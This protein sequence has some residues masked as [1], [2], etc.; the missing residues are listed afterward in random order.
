[1][2]N[3]HL[4]NCLDIY[5]F[6]Y[7]MDSCNISKDGSNLPDNIAVISI[8]D[9][10]NSKYKPYHYFTGSTTRIL[11]IDFDDIDPND[12][13]YEY[14]YKTADNG[15]VIYNNYIL[16]HISDSQSKEIVDFILNNKGKNFWIHCYAGISRSKA[17][18][19]FIADNIDGYSLSDCPQWL[20]YNTPNIYV[21]NKLTEEYKKII[22]C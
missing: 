2:E 4:L 22:D 8:C 20:N 7:I 15:Y 18:V 17:I 21:L 10:N 5:T 13:C 16:K 11:N 14:C 12:S 9:T 6:N 19:K 1:M 3:E